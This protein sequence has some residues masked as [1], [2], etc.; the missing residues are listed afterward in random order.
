M[1]RP[2]AT[3]ALLGLYFGVNFGVRTW[4]HWRATGTSGWRGLSGRMGSAEWFGGV[5]FVLG[6]ALGVAGPLATQFG[7]VPELLRPRPWWTDAV[8]VG[9][10][11]LG[12][13]GT[14]WAQFAMGDS[15]RIG[16]RQE[17]RTEFVERGPFRWVRNPIF[18]F[19]LLTTAG[20]AALLTNL[21]S[22]GALLC[23]AIGVELQ[24][25]FAEEPYL[26]RMHGDH[27]IEYCRRVG[28]FVPGVGCER[29]T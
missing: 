7:G 20:L 27:Y 21:L 22:I 10:V 9:T 16:V 5:L 4:R 14:T 23:L 12:I 2:I 25:R 24:V 8:A 3:L 11:L 29:P 13:S 17:E 18:S 28:R 1:S 26:R 19:M 15:W 6:I